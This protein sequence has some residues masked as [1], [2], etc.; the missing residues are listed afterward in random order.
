MAQNREALADP[1]LGG[2]L[3]AEALYDLALASG[4]DERTAGKLAAQR[5]LDRLRQ[6]LP[7]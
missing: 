2:T 1:N 4:Y 3:N 6:N 7:A 5:G